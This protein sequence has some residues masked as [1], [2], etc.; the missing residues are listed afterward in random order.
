[1]LKSGFCFLAGIFVA[2]TFP[3][4]GQVLFGWTQLGLD[5]VMNLINERISSG[6]F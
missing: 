6:G 1:M 5:W 3:D 2:F 4:V